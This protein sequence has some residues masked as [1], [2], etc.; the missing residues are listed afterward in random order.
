MPNL[1][2]IDGIPVSGDEKA[3]AEMYFIEQQGGMQNVTSALEPSLPGIVTTRSQA[4]LRV[5][6][7]QLNNNTDRNWGTT[8]LRNDFPNGTLLRTFEQQ[9]EKARRRV[10]NTRGASSHSLQ[11]LSTSDSTH[12]LSNDRYGRTSSSLNPQQSLSRQP[13]TSSSVPYIAHGNY[14]SYGVNGDLTDS[15]RGK[16]SR[17]K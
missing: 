3:K 8:A 2:C 12:S 5:T 14:S 15:N 1:L 7:V 17:Y 4:P 13:Q 10:A 11:T 16:N 6:T 9:Q